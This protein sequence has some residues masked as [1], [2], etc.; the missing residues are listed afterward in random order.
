MEPMT[1][2]RKGIKV[3]VLRIVISL[4]MLGVLFWQVDDLDFASAIPPWSMQTALWLGGALVLTFAA[5]GVSAARWQQVLTALGVHSRWR[6]LFSHY[7]AGQ[8]VSNVLPTTIGGDV[9][10]VSRLSR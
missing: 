10:R 6:H 1:K 4:A 9:L 5:I 7:L 3:L 2:E 8:F